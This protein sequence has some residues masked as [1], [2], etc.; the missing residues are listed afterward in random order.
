MAGKM[1]LVRVTVQSKDFVHTIDAMAKWLAEEGIVVPVSTFS[2][3]KDRR[4]ISFGFSS[5]AESKRFAAKFGG[6]L[7]EPLQV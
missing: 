5:D 6:E 4:S 1:Q 7:R 2:G 3:D